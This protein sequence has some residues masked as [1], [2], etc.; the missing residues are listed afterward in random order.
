MNELKRMLE[1]QSELDSRVM[2]ERGVTPS[3]I[4]KCRAMLHEIIELEDELGWKW[5]KKRTKAETDQIKEELID[6]FHFW[7]SIALDLEMDEK[8]IMNEYEKK[9]KINHE[10]QNHGY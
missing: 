1:Y 7:L 3:P 10:R 6:V 2:I 4:D 9:L 5:W 8:S